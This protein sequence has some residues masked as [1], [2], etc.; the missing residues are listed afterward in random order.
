MQGMLPFAEEYVFLFFLLLFPLVGF[1]RNLSL[2]ISLI[3]P[4]DVLTKWKDRDRGDAEDAAGPLHLAPDPPPIKALGGELAG[5][6][7]S[8][9]RCPCQVWLELDGCGSQPYHFGV[10]APPI[11]YSLF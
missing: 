11:L 7:A 10:G 5:E 4:P 8:A 2:E 9:H 6:E 3:F 1:N